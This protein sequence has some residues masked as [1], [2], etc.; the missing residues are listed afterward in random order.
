MVKIVIVEGKKFRLGVI[1]RRDPFFIMRVLSKADKP[2]AVEFVVKRKSD[3]GSV[4]IG[5]TKTKSRA[6]LILKATM[7]AEMLAAKTGRATM[8]A[9]KAAGTGSI[10]VLGALGRAF[11]KKRKKATPRK[12]RKKSK[13]RGKS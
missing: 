10:K 2:L 11:L 12:S 8:K 5:R 13:K 4:E 3:L 6:I 7:K 1:M 9:V